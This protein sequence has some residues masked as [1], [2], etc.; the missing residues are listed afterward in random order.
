MSRGTKLDQG[1]KRTEMTMTSTI[2]NT[3]AMTPHLVC[4][5]AS[6]AIE[7][8]KRAFGAEELMRLPG[9]DGRLM[10]AAVRINGATVMLVDENKDF[11][12]L[13]PATLG[14]TPVTI[15][16]GVPDAD[17]AFERAVA[18]GALVV[19]PLADQFWGDRYGLVSDPSGH[20]W[21]LVTP[22]RAPMS[23]AELREAMAEAFGGCGPEA[24]PATK[25]AAPA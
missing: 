18:A 14:G 1:A 2:E 10:H 23:E 6:E 9:S 24:M 7:F 16:L 11:G 17:A 13:S 5:D 15:N 21:A 12:A 20:R 8:Y 3:P 4:K 22:L 19:M 25:E